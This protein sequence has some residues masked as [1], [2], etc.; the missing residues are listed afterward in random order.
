MKDKENNYNAILTDTI[1]R[2]S[3]IFLLSSSDTQN[4]SNIL[5]NK[6][7]PTRIRFSMLAVEI[8]PCSVSPPSNAITGSNT[9]A[10]SRT[11]ILIRQSSE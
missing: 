1:F 8:V 9:V 7:E 3:S 2:D 4:Y 11:S 10:D 6:V 5:K